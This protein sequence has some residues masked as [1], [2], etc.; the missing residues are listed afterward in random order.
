MTTLQIE[1][2]EDLLAQTE[3][4]REGLEE[5]AREALLVRLYDLGKLSSGKAA[6]LL[7]L[8]RREFLGVLGKYGVSEFDDSQDVAV[9][10]RLAIEASRFQHKPVD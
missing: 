7:G 8:S 2:P 9:E 3:Q 10:A 4:T 1:Y 5:L 6:E